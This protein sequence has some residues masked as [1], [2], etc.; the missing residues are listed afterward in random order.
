MEANYNVVVG[1]AIHW[2]E[3]AMG[4]HVSPILKPPLTSLPT[5]SL[6]VVPVQ[7]ILYLMINIPLY[8][9]SINYLT[10]LKLINP[11]FYYSKQF[12]KGTLIHVSSCTPTNISMN[13]YLGV[14]NLKDDILIFCKSYQFPFKSTDHFMFLLT[15]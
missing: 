7:L 11:T 1:F 12:C 10:I 9:W 2:H 15:V 13:N 5:L 14:K 8:I 6:T 4:V 3:S